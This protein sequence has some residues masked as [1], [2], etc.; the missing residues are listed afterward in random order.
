MKKI[1][2]VSLNNGILDEMKARFPDEGYTFFTIP[3]DDEALDNIVEISP[4]LVVIEITDN[5]ALEA[6]LDICRKIKAGPNI[7]VIAVLSDDMFTDDFIR[8][9]AVNDFVVTSVNYGE[10]AARIK[11]I[12]ASRVKKD[13]SECIVSGDLIIDLAR[14]EVT[15]AGKVIILTYMEY[16]LLKFL[17]N[18]KGRVLTRDVLL[19]N[20]WGYDYFGGDRTVDVHIR[21]LRSKIE[22]PGHSFIETVRNIG[23]RFRE[24]A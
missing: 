9:D 6:T 8:S 23:Y 5:D 22:D 4:E 18:N 14:C 19:N 10:L 15:I 3:Y 17:A 2:V 12:F 7:P 16:E 24:S 1:L 13:L 20:V 21:R 11:R